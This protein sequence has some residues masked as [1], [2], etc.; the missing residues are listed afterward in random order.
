MTPSKSTTGSATPSNGSHLGRDARR[1][2]HTQQQTRQQPRH[3]QL[4]HRTPASLRH[5]RPLRPRHNRSP[6]SPIHQL[7]RRLRHR[8]SRSRI[9]QHRRHPH[10]Q[11]HQR[12][13]NHQD[14][15]RAHLG[16]SCDRLPTLTRRQKLR[17]RQLGPTRPQLQ[18]VHLSARDRRH[19]HLRHQSQQLAR[20]SPTVA[21][22]TNKKAGSQ[23]STPPSSKTPKPKPKQHYKTTSPTP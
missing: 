17:R 1:R 6:Q 12:W 10:H 7:D 9:R 4:N 18:T 23:A 11:R 15:H 16:R 20:T 3:R 22:S 19:R 21:P 8:R 2:P 14:A 5:P 13:A